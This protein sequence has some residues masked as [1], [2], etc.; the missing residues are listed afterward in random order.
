MFKNTFKNNKKPT[1]NKLGRVLL[2]SILLQFLILSKS[3]CQEFID[4]IV[5]TINNNPITLSDINKKYGKNYTFSDFR[6]N[7]EAQKVLDMVILD[8]IVRAEAE[9]KRI[10]VS[11]AEVDRYI[12]QVA[13]RNSLSKEDFLQ[14][15]ANRNISLNSYKEQ[16][17]QDILK[18]KIASSIV[19]NGANVSDE[20]VDKFLERS[21]KNKIYDSKISLS[22]ICVY[23]EGKTEA[24]A[25]ELLKKILEELEEEDFSDVAKKYSEAPNAKDGGALGEFTLSELSSDIFNAVSSLS[26]GQV[27]KIVDTENAYFIFKVNQKDIQGK[28]TDAEKKA[29]RE[30]LEEQSIKEAINDYFSKEIYKNYSIEKKIN[31]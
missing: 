16:I 7:P 12:D 25:L 13:Q 14:E 29:A 17:K 8:E 2:C 3:F 1:N 4:A 24:Q 26:T 6:T 27:S 15:L 5:V 23:K 9:K 21:K 11:D 18:S 30:Q 31:G 22:Q 10:H 19:Q 28:A 20:E